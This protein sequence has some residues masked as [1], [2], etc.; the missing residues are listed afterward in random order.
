MTIALHSRLKEGHEQAYERDHQYIPD[1]M[2]AE[3]A[4]V[5]IREWRIWRSGRDL[6]HLVDCDDIEAAMTALEESPA[7]ARW[8]EFINQH[9]EGFA[10]FGEGPGATSVP[11]VW[12]LTGQTAG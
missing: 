6:F 3:F 5:G 1:E 8:Q 7:N 4:R 12:T 10:T 11:Q 2:V 9:L